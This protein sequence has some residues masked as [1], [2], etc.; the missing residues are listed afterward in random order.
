MQSC[1]NTYFFFCVYPQ[2]RCCIC[3]NTLFLSFVTQKK[4]R[5]FPTSARSEDE[6]RYFPLRSPSLLPPQP[7]KY[8]ERVARTQSD[9]CLAVASVERN[10]SIRTAIS[11][12]ALREQTTSHS[13]EISI[14]MHVSTTLGDMS[15]WGDGIRS[16]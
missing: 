10:P 12:L 1:D 4:P 15:N 9:R 8:H 3:P 16:I 5:N 13:P 6:M 11:D 7:S 2:S 14:D